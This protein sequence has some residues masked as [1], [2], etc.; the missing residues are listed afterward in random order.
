M[1]GMARAYKDEE[2]FS[3]VHMGAEPT[4]KFSKESLVE[5]RRVSTASPMQPYDR[6]LHMVL[7]KHNDGRHFFR[8]DRD[9]QSSLNPNKII[10]YIVGED[11]AEFF[12]NSFQEIEEMFAPVRYGT[13]CN[14]MDPY[15]IF[16]RVRA[17]A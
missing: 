8:Q 7:Y 13:G 4:V 14:T 10:W 1:Q 15:S 2:E 3:L 11:F 6:E 5:L 17:T 12:L 16:N 9:P